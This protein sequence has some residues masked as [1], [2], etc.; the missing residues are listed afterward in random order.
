MSLFGGIFSKDIK[1]ESTTTNQD[2][3]RVTTLTDSLNTAVTQN[4][5][6]TQASNRTYNSAFDA[7]DS[8][9]TV[10]SSSFVN[11]GAGSDGAIPTLDF[12]G[13]RSL[14]ANPADLAAIWANGHT[15]VDP[16]ANKYN[17][18]FASQSAGGNDFLKS[19][20][21]MVGTTWNGLANATT[22]ARETP[23]TPAQSMI[24]YVVIGAAVVA[25]AWLIVKL[26]KK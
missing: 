22:A 3:S 26:F 18:D 2:N 19:V 6:L 7:V 20:S 25:A 24:K 21:D 11:I 17:F 15:A 4:T 16:N 13:L 10:N 14:F 9:N 23:A 8:F 1:N 12:T 5:A